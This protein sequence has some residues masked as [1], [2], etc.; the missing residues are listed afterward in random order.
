MFKNHRRAL[1]GYTKNTIS[2]DVHMSL[3]FMVGFWSVA[4]GATKM[5]DVS[6]TDSLE[7][8]SRRDIRLLAFS[9]S[10]C[11]GLSSLC[12]ILIMLLLCSRSIGKNDFTRSLV[13][14]SCWSIIT[15]ASL[16]LLVLVSPAGETAYMMSR[17]MVIGIIVRN[18]ITCLMGAFCIVFFYVS[19]SDRLSLM[20]YS[21]YVCPMFLVMAISQ[22]LVLSDSY[23]AVNMG[24][25]LACTLLGRNASFIVMSLISFFLSCLVLFTRHMHGRYL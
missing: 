11:F 18:S 23:I 13:I 16:M 25:Y 2:I 9:L 15:V 14:G 17:H 3:L 19:K 21:T 12:E 1:A 5:F 10:L 4:W 8:I 6:N 20:T 24:G 7:A 22:G